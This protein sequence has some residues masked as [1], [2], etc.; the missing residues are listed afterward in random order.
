MTVV[1]D[2]PFGSMD[3]FRRNHTVN[4]TYRCGQNCTQ[5]VVLSHDPGFLHLLWERVAP[6]DRKTLSL[7][8]IGE[9]NTTIAEWNIERAVQARYFADISTL[10]NFYGDAEGNP[11]DVVQKIRPVL[12]AYC[13][14]LYPTQFGDQMMMGGIITVIRAAGETHPLVTIVDDFDE[15]NVYCRRYHHGDNLNAATE[16]L[17]DA[18]LQ[19]YVGRA[20][21]LVGCLT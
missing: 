12:E 17:D 1:F 5:V 13:R 19:G 7:T 9:D 18:E 6:T 10:Q 8:R 15:L 16:P 2:D 11:R 4:Q 21:R 3:G 20:L 14:N